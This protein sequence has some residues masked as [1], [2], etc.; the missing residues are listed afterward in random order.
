MEVEQ[1]K[2]INHTRTHAVLCVF[3]SYG[4]AIVSLN[5]AHVAFREVLPHLDVIPLTGN[6]VLMCF[7]GDHRARIGNGFRHIMSGIVRAAVG[8]CCTSNSASGCAS[9]GHP[10]RSSLVARDRF[11]VFHGARATAVAIS[12]RTASALSVGPDFAS[13]EITSAG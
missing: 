7:G 9:T 3:Q 2:V 4:I 8:D 12:I 13:R 10:G 5:T 1:S 11:I 6:D